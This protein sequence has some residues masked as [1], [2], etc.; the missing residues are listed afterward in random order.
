M[1]RWIRLAT[2][3]YPRSWRERYD[4]EFQVL[5]DDVRPGW[6]ELLDVM[7]SALIMRLTIDSTHWKFGTALALAGAVLA[8]GVSFVVPNRYVSSALIRF[9]SDDQI[10]QIQQS[11]LSRGSL[12]ELICR[13]S[14]NLYR[15]ERQ[16]KPLEDIVEDM[17]RDIH[18]RRLVI[19]GARAAQITFAYPD[20]DK[21]Q[22]TTRALL[23][24]MTQANVSVNRQRRWAW[25]WASPTT[26]A[27]AG[28]NLEI[29]DP[30]SLA[31][32]ST[33]TNRLRIMVFGLGAG[34]LLGLLTARFRQQR[35]WTLQ[36][37][38]F[39]VAGSAI[40]L[41][42]SL[43]VPPTYVSSA[44]MLLSP[45]MVPERF[46]GSLAPAPMAEWLPRMEQEVLSRASL[47]EIIRSEGLYPGL[48]EEEALDKMRSRD[49][50][51]R[52]LRP[53]AAFRISF[54]YPDRRKAQA[55]VRAL[56]TRF[57]EQNLRA[58]RDRVKMAN[59]P[60]AVTRLLDH[61]MGPNLEV[62]DWASLPERPVAPNR[63]AIAACGLALGLVLGA[64][65]LRLARSNQPRPA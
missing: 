32:T 36:M 64:I 38:G 1:R 40:G 61:K 22:A 59:E 15:R 12:V 52:A 49:V 28:E 23:E 10:A 35:R 27:P 8:A 45:P 29:L 55:V 9:T 6:R 42:V 2:R 16:R 17:R 50:G 60:E 57:V 5:L 41:A 53:A 20:K 30:P 34:L 18:I 24:Q 13:P 46:L 44:V 58:E 7:R 43:L 14:L 37:A 39:G 11:V 33:K 48:R 3:L 63:L 21:A 19:G 54:T 25:Q 4:V 26:P 56:V 62:L 31:Q 51:I 47:V 65:T